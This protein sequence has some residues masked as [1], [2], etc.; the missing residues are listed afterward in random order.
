MY[1][2]LR[3]LK[4]STEFRNFIPELNTFKVRHRV[5]METVKCWGN[6]LVADL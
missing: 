3:A 1:L 4:Y 2:F 5:K 6:S